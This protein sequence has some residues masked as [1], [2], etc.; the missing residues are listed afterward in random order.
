MILSYSIRLFSLCCA[1]FFLVHMV[2]R[3][4]VWL[5]ERPALRFAERATPRAA[6]RLLFL[7]RTLPPGIALVAVLGI[8]AP[9]YVRFEQNIAAEQAGPVC[10]A[11][12]LLGAL[13]WAVALGRGARAAVSSLRFIR[14]CSRSGRTVPVH[15]EPPQMLVIQGARPFLAQSGIFRPQFVISQC[16]LNEFSPEELAAA[17]SH[18][19]AH[20]ISRDNLKRLL[21]AF[22]PD[23]LPLW[24][25]FHSL[26]RNWAKFAERAADD[27]VSAMGEAPA[28]SL[29]A[30]LVRLARMGGAV[31]LAP[32]A[33]LATS[34]LG[35]SDD[36]SGRVSRLLAVTPAKPEAP[37]GRIPVLWGAASVFATCT[38]AALVWPA[39]LSPVHELLERLLH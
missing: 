29:A 32:R 8:C 21:F 38:L 22:L 28:L 25:G 37:L 16:L 31:D 2:A 30:A 34:P 12:A 10:L 15:G 24:P 4:A 1:S 39:A 26:E 23:V 9:S 27:S 13:L 19:R 20:W 3:L 18:E 35:G 7:M 6:A 17:L 36:L 5:A 11:I 33:P 14:L